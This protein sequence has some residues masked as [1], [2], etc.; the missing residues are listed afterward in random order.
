MAQ[1]IDLLIIGPNNKN[2][3]GSAEVKYFSKSKRFTEGL[4]KA[5]FCILLSLFFIFVPVVHLLAV[6]MLHVA[7]KTSDA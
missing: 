3:T 2:S 1:R 4:K 6:P 5:G 7:T